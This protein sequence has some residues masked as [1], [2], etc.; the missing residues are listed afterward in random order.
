MAGTK[1][2][3]KASMSKEDRSDR[4]VEQKAAKQEAPEKPQSPAG[5]QI[6][7]NFSNTSV[8][9]ALLY[10]EDSSGIERYMLRLE[11]GKSTEQSCKSPANW[12]VKVGGKELK[13]VANRDKALFEITAGGVKAS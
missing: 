5:T 4:M 1:K 13:V 11:P 6:K 2:S 3:K 9:E 12:T 8:S 7:V 10:L